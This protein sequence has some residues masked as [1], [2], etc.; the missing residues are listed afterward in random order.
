MAYEHLRSEERECRFLYHGRGVRPAE[1]ARRHR[2]HP[3]I[4]LR[5]FLRPAVC[6]ARTRSP[7]KVGATDH[8]PGCEVWVTGGCPTQTGLMLTNARIPLGRPAHPTILW[9]PFRA[10]GR[11]SR[12]SYPALLAGLLTVAPSGLMSGG[13]LGAEFY[14]RHPYHAWQKGTVE[15]AI[16]EMRRYL[17]RQVHRSLCASFGAGT[18]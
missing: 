15:N 13:A 5:G 1:I 12:T 7:D 10:N 14:F 17:P 18:Q 3:S 2:R 8:S 16:G 6:P 11:E 9:R 4:I